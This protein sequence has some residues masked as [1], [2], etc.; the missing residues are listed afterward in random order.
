M[1]LLA[2]DRL[3]EAYALG[4]DLLQ[5]LIDSDRWSDL[6]VHDP[7]VFY[8]LPPEI[9][10]HWFRIRDTVRLD[11]VLLPKTRVVHWYA[12]VRTRTRVA[13]VSPSYVREHRERQ[14]YSALVSSCISNLPEVV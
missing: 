4:P 11:R 2:P 12:S 7:E 8:P 3:L 6:I 10:E 13:L 1:S 14:F 5:S 9:S